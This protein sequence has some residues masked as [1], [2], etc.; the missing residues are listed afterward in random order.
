[1]QILKRAKRKKSDPMN[2]YITD[3]DEKHNAV[4]KKNIVLPQEVLAFKLLLGADLS[5][6]DTLIILTGVDFSKKGTL[7]DQAKK[8]L[9][10]FK[11]GGAISGA[12]SSNNGTVPVVK[13]EPTWI[14]ENEEVLAAAGF[15]RMPSYGRGGRSRGRGGYRGGRGGGQFYNSPYNS[16][17]NSPRNSPHSSPTR[18]GRAGS[19]SRSE[20]PVNPKRSDGS[21]LTCHS[22]GSYRHLISECPHSWENVNTVEEEKVCL[23]TG[24]KRETEMLDKEA[25]KQCWTQ[26]VALLLLVKDGS[27]VTWNPLIRRTRGWWNY[28]RAQK[29]SSLGEGRGSFP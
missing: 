2:S 17:Q 24:S 6:E 10:K 4:H 13:V 14:S 19:A 25:I 11:G 7:Y 5:E 15:H 16:P 20:R 1:M 22:C 12:S 23:F 18:R 29:F 8:S 3:F 21:Y 26:L 27:I 28:N 9:K